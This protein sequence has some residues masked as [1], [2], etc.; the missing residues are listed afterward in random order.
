MKLPFT[1]NGRTFFQGFLSAFRLHPTRVFLNWMEDYAK[2]S[3]IENLQGDLEKVGA[4]MRNV[5][6]PALIT[7]YNESI[8]DYIKSH[9][10]RFFL[11][12][13]LYT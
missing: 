5:M 8:T 3:D 10:Y 12:N 1:Q 7:S 4:D 11:H 2:R 9:G 6:L 13:R